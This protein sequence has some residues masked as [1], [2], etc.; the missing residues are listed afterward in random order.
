MRRLMRDLMSTLSGPPE[1]TMHDF[2][3]SDLATL[4]RAAL[5]WWTQTGAPL[6]ERLRRGAA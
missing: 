4:D 6:L 1:R 3:P 2:Y 5:D